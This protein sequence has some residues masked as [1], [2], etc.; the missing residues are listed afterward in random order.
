MIFNSNKNPI[1]T[2]IG[3]VY[4]IDEAEI[5]RFKKVGYYNYKGIKEGQYKKIAKLE[6][7]W[8]TKMSIDGQEYLNWDKIHGYKLEYEA[9]PLAS[10]SRYREDVIAW[11]L[12]DFDLAM[13]RKEKLEN[14]QRADRK[15]RAQLGPKGKKH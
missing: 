2:M 13:E 9:E 3:G 12:D 4:E 7:R 14:I 1:D 11:I 5:S 15:W 8:T 6:G 10:D